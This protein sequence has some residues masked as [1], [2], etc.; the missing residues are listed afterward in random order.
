MNPPPSKVES[1]ILNK[2]G[3]GVEGFTGSFNIRRILNY[4]DNKPVEHTSNK[5]KHIRDL[6]STETVKR[7]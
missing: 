7:Q 3:W 2:D 4:S 5:S 1:L 6:S